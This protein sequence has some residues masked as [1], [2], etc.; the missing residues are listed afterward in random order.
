MASDYISRQDAVK[1]VHE[2]IYD[3]FDVVDDDDETPMTD[4]DKKLLE[5]NKSISKRI[6][7]IPTAD[8]VQIVSC[9]DCVFLEVLNSEQYYARCNWHGRLFPSFG[10]PDTRYYFCADCQRREDV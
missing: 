8:V 10:N 5:V 4:L 3:F 9:K 7:S 1:A 6:A 2:A